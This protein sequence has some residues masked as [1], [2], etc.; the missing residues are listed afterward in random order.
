MAT[1]SHEPL[2]DPL[3]L[4]NHV[5]AQR[6]PLTKRLSLLGQLADNLD[7]R[8]SRLPLQSSSS[9]R[10]MLSEDAGGDSWPAAPKAVLPA[11]EIKQLLDAAYA[12]VQSHIWPRLRRR[13]RVVRPE[14]LTAQQQQWLRTYFCRQLYPLLTP[15]AVD[16]A[17]PFPLI[18][19]GAIYLLVTLRAVGQFCRLVN[20]IENSGQTVSSTLP[21]TGP[22]RSEREVYGLVELNTFTP[23]VVA[24]PAVVDSTVSTPTLL[25]REE[26]VRHYIAMLFPQIDVTGV[27][28]FRVICAHH[29]QAAAPIDATPWS[30]SLRPERGRAQQKQQPVTHIDIEQGAPPHLVQWLTTHLRATPDCVFPCPMPLSIADFCTLI[31]YLH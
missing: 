3:V 28:Q 10:G 27:Y 16:P 9:G 7:L 15:L 23:R 2:A 19:P 18:R 17:R 29:R 20:D 26:I 30:G 12:A 5:R 14:S 24:V 21:I 13:L 31:D 22:N 4:L 6:L 25:W 11:G 1:I 8:L